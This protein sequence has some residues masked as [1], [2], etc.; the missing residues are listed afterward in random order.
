MCDEVYPYYPVLPKYN[1]KGE[2]DYELGL[3]N[4]NIPFGS[5]YRFWSNYDDNA[6]ASNIYHD[7]TS[8][9]VDLAVDEIDG[10][11][12]MDI[13]GNDNRGNLIADYRIE[14][15]DETRKPS[16]TKIIN[17]IKLGSKDEG[18]Y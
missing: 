18:A 13:S 2:F 9:I 15:D 3:Q 5:P 6:A 17:K 10:N 7:D 12:L 11:Q 16:S 8:L 1:W 14:F 4:N